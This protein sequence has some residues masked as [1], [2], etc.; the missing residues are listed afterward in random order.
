[1][2]LPKILVLTCAYL[3][4]ESRR[5][6][7]EANLLCVGRIGHDVAAACTENTGSFKDVAKSTA[8]QKAAQVGLKL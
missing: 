2:R 7:L 3:A 4:H 8:Q 1:M 5:C 6:P